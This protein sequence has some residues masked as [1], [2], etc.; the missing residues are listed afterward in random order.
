MQVLCMYCKSDLGYKK[1]EGVSHGVCPA[2]VPRLL[3]E[4]GLTMEDLEA[5]QRQKEKIT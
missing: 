1:G 3:A 5:F 4:W 2:C